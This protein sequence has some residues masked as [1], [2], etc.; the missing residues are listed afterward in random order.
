[1]VTAY[2]SQQK[3]TDVS[4]SPGDLQ[5]HTQK[6]KPGDFCL[7]SYNASYEHKMGMFAYGISFGV[8]SQPMREHK[9]PSV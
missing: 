2:A 7:A 9:H 3:P 4:D 1:M 8:I 5:Y 6:Q